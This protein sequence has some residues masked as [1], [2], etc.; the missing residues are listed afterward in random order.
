MRTLPDTWEVMNFSQK[1]RVIR[2]L[3]AKVVVSPKGVD[4][5]LRKGEYE[6]IIEK[7]PR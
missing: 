1:Q 7:T 4:V 5:Y 3:V 2:G 6:K